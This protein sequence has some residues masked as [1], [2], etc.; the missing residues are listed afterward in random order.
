MHFPCESQ[1][2]ITEIPNVNLFKNPFSHTK[3]SPKILYSV[4]YCVTKVWWTFSQHCVMH[5]FP[6]KYIALVG[7]EKLWLC[8]GVV[9]CQPPRAPVSCAERPARPRAPP[10]APISGSVARFQ[11]SKQAEC[12]LCRIARLPLHH[13]NLALPPRFVASMHGP[14][15]ID[16]YLHSII[17]YS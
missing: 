1:Y 14:H 17:H 8:R 16:A 9:G 12:A 5:I 10:L 6:D 15:Y 11:P 3:L 2:Y 7:V 4:S 13:T